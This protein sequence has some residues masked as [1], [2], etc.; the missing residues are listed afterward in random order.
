MGMIHAPLN[1]QLVHAIDMPLTHAF[2]DEARRV[3]KDDFRKS[4]L[5]W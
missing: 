3:S 1:L 4:G 2:L 5:M